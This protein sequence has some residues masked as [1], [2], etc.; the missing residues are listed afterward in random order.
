MNPLG[1]TTEEFLTAVNADTRG[2]ASWYASPADEDAYLTEVSSALRSPEH[3]ERWAAA[4]K[5]MKRD[6]E[7]QLV[8]QNADIAEFRAQQPT[9][10]EYRE[11]H[12]NISRKRADMIRF[13]SGVENKLDE[14]M[15]LLRQVDVDEPFYLTA[16]EKHRSTVLYGTDKEAAVADENLWQVLPGPAL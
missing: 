16:I 5:K 1:D 9:M 11:Y 4:L 13:K 7:S 3:L 10:D 14:A 8:S 6:V 2:Q 15:M 12:R